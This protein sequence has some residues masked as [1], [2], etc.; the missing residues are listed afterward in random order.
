MKNNKLKG[1]SV[2]RG[3]RL[4]KWT[5]WITHFQ[6]FKNKTEH[7]PGC[8]RILS[9]HEHSV[10]GV[11]EMVATITRIDRDGSNN[12]NKR[13]QY[14]SIVHRMNGDVSRMNRDVMGMDRD[15]DRMRNRDIK[16]MN[17]D[18]KRMNRD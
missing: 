11:I 6:A 3:A 12:K 14:Q 7:V 18:V 2:A 1:A 9:P 17:S 5:S 10:L 16:R 13:R 4:R 15:I 8:A